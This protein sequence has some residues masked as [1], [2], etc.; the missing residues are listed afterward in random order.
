MDL[1]HALLGSLFTI[2]ITASVF[3]IAYKVLMIGNDVSEMKETLKQIQRETAIPAVIA[4]GGGF[5]GPLPDEFDITPE[6][7]TPDKEFVLP[8][9]LSRR[10][11]AERASHRDV[12]DGLTLDLKSS[13]QRH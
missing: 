7:R 12:S 1:I 6:S 5:P 2:L 3:F 4:G 13:E 10:L 8:P 11:E 9:P